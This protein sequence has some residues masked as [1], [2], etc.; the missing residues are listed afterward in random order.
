MFSGPDQKFWHQ[1]LKS[2]QCKVP[3]Q[4][5]WHQQLKSNH[6][7]V[8]CVDTAIN[9]QQDVLKDNVMNFL[10]SLAKSG[11]VDSWIG[12]P[13]CRSVSKLRH[14]QPGPAV[15]RSREGPERFGKKDLTP[16][17]VDLVR[18]DTVLWL[19]FREWRSFAA[20]MEFL[21]WMGIKVRALSFGEEDVN[22]VLERLRRGECLAS[23]EFKRL[24]GSVEAVAGSLE[25]MKA[26]E[27]ENIELAGR[28][29][30]LR[31]VMSD[32]EQA[33]CEKEVSG[34]LL[35]KTRTYS[36][37]EVRKDPEPWMEAMKA[38][39]HSL[40]KNGIIAVLSEKWWWLTLLASWRLWESSHVE[41]LGKSQELY[42][43]WSL[44]PAIG[45][46]TVTA[47]WSLGRER[48]NGKEMCALS[49]CSWKMRTFGRSWS[50][51]WMV[52]RPLVDTWPFMLTTSWW[53]G[54]RWSL[55][56]REASSSPS[57]GPAR[58]SLLALTS[59]WD[60]VEWRWRGQRP[61]K[62][63]CTKPPTLA[64][65]FHVMVWRKRHRFWRFQL[66]PLRNVHRRS[67]SSWL[68]RS[69]ASCCGFQAALGRTFQRLWA[70]C[71]L[72]AL[73]LLVG[74]WSLGEMCWST[75]AV[76]W[77][78]AWSMTR[79][80]R[81]RLTPRSYWMCCQMQASV[82]MISPVCRA[83]WSCTS[84][85]WCIGVPRSRLCKLLA[86]RRVNYQPWWTLCKQGGQ[87]GDWSSSLSAIERWTC[88]CLP[89]IERLWCGRALA[90]AVETGEIAMYYKPGSELL[91]DAL[92]KV[93]PRP[94][95]EKF[96]AGIKLRAKK[97]NVLEE[98]TV[99][100]DERCGIVRHRMRSG[101]G[102]IIVA[103]S[104]LP[105]VS[106]ERLDD[107]V[108]ESERC[109]KLK[110]EVWRSGRYF[111]WSLECWL[112]GSLPRTTAFRGFAKCSMGMRMRCRYAWSSL[113]PFFLKRQLMEQPVLT[114]RDRK[115][116]RWDQEKGLLCRLALPFVFR[117]VYT[118]ASPLE[119]ALLQSM[120]W[121]WVLESW[122]RTRGVKWRFSSTTTETM[123]CPLIVVI[124]WH[125]LLCSQ[126]GAQQALEARSQYQWPSKGVKFQ[127]RLWWLRD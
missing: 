116:S 70:G 85:E 71:L 55:M 5:F 97:F 91:A 35:L 44:H 4:K 53:Q 67:R 89:T 20:A 36:L 63:L 121:R 88:A 28:V 87:R 115:H 66:K 68:K 32:E 113:M 51:R 69:Q 29:A 6:C 98:E 13:P 102:L 59:R 7:K 39:Y 15:L 12:G 125:S 57:G 43:G 60:F 48:L 45:A 50:R 96:C 78:M 38:E 24:D 10:I 61:V 112:C 109:Q 124:V 105:V 122:T 65:F 99:Q 119:V 80:I 110:V 9:P 62:S 120:V 81:S 73:V 114:W 52:Q 95:L 26:L 33:D 41:W 19:R 75:C 11:C 117:K 104:L 8:L 103:L 72:P 107:F 100:I 56:L 90:Q 47:L 92:T 21:R 37:S 40:L 14:V 118:D 77:I 58:L 82:Q 3:D 108:M 86:Q 49:G 17:Q 111:S 126:K 46:A 16:S 74:F 54:R 42:T 123:E 94:L 64:G 23:E 83:L 93:V 18:D 1:Q 27:A 31:K 127:M 2:N 34:E 25:L 76:P 22:D 101:L 30:S 84:E 79:V 106:G